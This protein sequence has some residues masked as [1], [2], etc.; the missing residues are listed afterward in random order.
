LTSLPF[1]DVGGVLADHAG[2]EAA[3]QAAARRYVEQVG[4]RGVAER[5]CRLGNV[6]F[7]D[8]A[9]NVKVIMAMRLPESSTAL[10]AGLKSKLRSQVNKPQREGLRACLGGADLLDHFYPVFARNM[11][12]LGSPVHSRKWISAVVAAYGEAARVGVVY[13]ADGKPVAGG[14]IL[15]HG[16]KISIPWASSLRRYN[17]LNPNMLLYWTF[18]A[19]GADHG[20]TV[21]DFGRSTL[22]EGTYRFKEQWGAKPVPLIWTYFRTDGTKLSG[23]ARPGRLRRWAESVWRHAPLPFCNFVGP[24]IRRYLSL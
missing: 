23:I 13:L 19:Y 15:L 16:K 22:G 21:F 24:G 18:L 20:F 17:T 5:S 10:L 11:R 12:D 1:C 7:T 3:L 6:T 2:I 8:T 14:I 9:A 4:A